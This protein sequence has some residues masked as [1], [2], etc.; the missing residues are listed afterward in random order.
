MLG[1]RTVY[2]CVDKFSHELIFCLCMR[3][4]LRYRELLSASVLSLVTVI[5]DL[6]N[7]ALCGLRALL[8]VKP[9]VQ[10]VLRE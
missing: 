3:G 4:V 10:I 8:R 5:S 6:L 9:S 7:E 2:I 1:L